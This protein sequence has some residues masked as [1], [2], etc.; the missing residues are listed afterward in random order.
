MTDHNRFIALYCR[1]STDEQAREGVSLD[2]QQ[3]RLK[4]YCRA[5]GWDE[6]PLLFIDDGY[7]AKNLDRPQL[8]KLLNEINKGTISKILV[9]KL[10]RL[11][12]RLLDLLRLI[13]T[14]Q[15]QKVSFI[16]ISESFD[17][18]TPSG[19]L[20][21]QVLGAVAEFERE[22]IRERVFDNMLH[23][24]NQ[25]KWL[26][27]S[28]YGYDLKEKELIINEV[29]S[30]V[31]KR[32]FDLYLNK[33]LGYYSIAKQ[34]NEEGIPSKQKKEWSIRS[35][36]LML[37]NPVYKG[38]LM[39]NRV[40][41]SS[42][43]QV[44]KNEDEWVIIEHSHPVIITEEVWEA[45]QKRVHKKNMPSRAKTSPHLLGGLLKCGKCGASMSISWTGSRTKRKR[46][47]RCSANKNKGT[48]TS[49]P[50][51]ATDVESWFKH[52]LLHLSNSINQSYVIMIANQVKEEEN[53]EIQQQIRS[54]KNRYKRKVEAYTAGLIELVDLQNEKERME[55]ILLEAENREVPPSFNASELEEVLNNKISTIIDAIDTL[56]VVEA[57][58][59]VQ[60]LVEKVILF[61]EKDI[62][63]VLSVPT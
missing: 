22:R 36:K 61:E 20:T 9:T 53:N 14:F 16:S 49:K 55:R 24:A 18:N 48:C 5:M 26:S 37:T 52:G 6:H 29:E 43:K 39:W 33:G 54:A 35:I 10:D 51:N 12:R 56:P 23:A 46:V 7:S 1:V 60:T 58:S 27:Q 31:V 8:N 13:D 30:K 50:Y 19:R 25:G 11:S 21:L 41:R 34:L 32:V 47:Y 62:E 28:P 40:D 15:D 2:E 59:F 42:Q 44:E 3:E 63:I 38:T 4:A 45:V 17:T 57:K